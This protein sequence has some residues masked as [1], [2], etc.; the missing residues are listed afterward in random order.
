MVELQFRKALSSG[1][2][3]FTNTD[4]A[5]LTSPS[6]G[7]HVLSASY[8]AQGN[9]AASSAT[10]NLHV[11][12]A[13]S[14]TTVNC[15]A[16]VIY[17]GLPL[18]PCTVSVTGAGGLSLTPAP[19]YTNNTNVGTATASYNF[20]GDANHNGSNDSKTFTIE[21][22]ASVTSV[23]CPASVTYNG[24]AQ[25]P[26]TATVTGIGGLNDS[27]TVSYT[28]NINAGTASAS[29]SFAG[30]ANHNGSSDSKTFT[31]EKAASVTSVTCPASVTYNG[32]AAD[33]VHSDGDWYWRA[34]RFAHGELHK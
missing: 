17:T 11:D 7:D 30:D 20:A 2:A 5:A 6:A 31:I 21:K 1:S 29:A 34:Q 15:P 25:T 9:F 12:Q 23:T 13:P 19:T 3:T 4:I 28:N 32:A 33:S 22:A 16:S 18:T 8:A 27:L 24:A 26:C 14:I 10:G